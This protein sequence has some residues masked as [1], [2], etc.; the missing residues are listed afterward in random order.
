MKNYPKFYCPR[1]N[2]WVH[3]FYDFYNN[4]KIVENTLCCEC[5]TWTERVSKGWK[6]VVTRLYPEDVEITEATVKKFTGEVVCSEPDN[7]VVAKNL[8]RVYV[9][10]KN[11]DA[12]IFKIGQCLTIKSQAH[13]PPTYST[14]TN[15]WGMLITERVRGRYYLYLED[16]EIEEG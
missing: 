14:H 1:C 7:L 10:Y 6:N 8:T 11:R 2:D 13:F 15:K 16:V 12:P 9:Y 4:R 5:G 3:H